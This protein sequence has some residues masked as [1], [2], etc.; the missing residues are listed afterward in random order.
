MNPLE[1]PIPPSP[2]ERPGPD[3][4]L[5]DEVDARILAGVRDIYQVTDPMPGD[6]VERVRFALALEDLD[7]DVFRR[8]PEPAPLAAAARGQEESRTVT[9]DSESLTIM[10]SITATGEQV[11]RLDGWLAPP[12]SHRVELRTERGP[13]LTTADEQGRFALDD[14][15]HGLAQ[16]VV[17]PTDGQPSSLGRSVVTPSIVV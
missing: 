13:L 2:D 8:F 12:G 7:V 5:L 3:Q 14:V 1:N 6:L 16:L 15:P 4:A 17:H 10:V 11:V 9:F